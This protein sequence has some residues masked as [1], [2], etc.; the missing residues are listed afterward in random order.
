[1]ANVSNGDKERVLHDCTYIMTL[2]AKH[3]E[4]SNLIHKRLFITH[5]VRILLTKKCN[6]KGIY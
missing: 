6:Q 3:H 2:S 1:M 4:E 5:E